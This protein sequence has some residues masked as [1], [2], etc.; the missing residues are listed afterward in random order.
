MKNLDELFRN[1]ARLNAPDTLR[2]RVMEG[3]CASESERKPG[4]LDAVAEWFRLTLTHPARVGFAL[5]AVAVAVAISI[6]VNAPD[7]KAPAPTSVVADMSQINDYMNETLDDAYAGAWSVNG[8]PSLE[9]DD[10]NEFVK[11]HVESVF[12]IDGGSDNA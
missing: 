10:V 1:T 2:K 7:I 6:A 5:G 8:A 3:V 4:W 12:W 9:P 11:A